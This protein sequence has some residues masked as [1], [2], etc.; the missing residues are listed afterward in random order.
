MFAA[1]RFRASRYLRENESVC[2]RA[3][4]CGNARRAEENNKTRLWP[5]LG[6]TGQSDRRPS[7]NEH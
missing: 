1:A 7:Y 4:V 6:K 2:A 5:R 3:R